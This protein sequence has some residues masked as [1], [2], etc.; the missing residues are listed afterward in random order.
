[1][2]KKRAHLLVAET[3]LFFWK[4]ILFWSEENLTEKLQFQEKT[5]ATEYP[6]LFLFDGRGEY[7]L[8]KGSLLKTLTLEVGS[9]Y[10]PHYSYAAQKMDIA[11]RR[12][13]KSNQH[14]VEILQKLSKFAETTKLSINI[15]KIFIE[16]KKH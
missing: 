7:N 8:E 16:K 11:V 1:M 12:S 4:M 3:L 6:E 13:N 10:Q 2:I 9:N 5:S 14:F 15:T